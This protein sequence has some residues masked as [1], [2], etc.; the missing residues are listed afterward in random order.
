VNTSREREKLRESF[1]P[2][3]IKLLFI[4]ESPPASGRFFYSANSGLYRAMRGAFQIAESTIQDESFLK[5]F[6]ERGCYLTD[7]SPEPIDH[8]APEERRVLRR[9]AE[10]HL[11]QQ[12]KRLQPLMIAPVLRSIAM[13]VENAASLAAWRGRIVQLPY[14]GRWSRHREAFLEALVPVIQRL[15]Q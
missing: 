1:R 5:V 15:N 12:I 3:D 13:N 7:L 14:P 6:K 9:R 2:P 11:A 4:G 10:K 8:L